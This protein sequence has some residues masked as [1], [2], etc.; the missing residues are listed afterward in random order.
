MNLSA[1]YQ[2]QKHLLLCIWEEIE[3]TDLYDEHP[4]VVREFTFCMD[5]CDYAL[6]KVEVIEYIE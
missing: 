4:E 5:A 1:G 2:E 6:V 3:M